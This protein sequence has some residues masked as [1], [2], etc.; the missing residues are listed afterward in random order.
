MANELERCE[1]MRITYQTIDVDQ[2][3]TEIQPLKHKQGPLLP[4]LHL[5]QEHYGYIPVSIQAVIQQELKL[6]N[7]FISG[8]VSFYELFH[9]IPTGIHHIGVCTGTSCHVQ[10]SHR[11]LDELETILG[12]KEGETTKDGQFTIIPVKCLGNCDTSPNISIDN[13]SYTAVDSNSLKQLL[14]Q[15]K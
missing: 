9:D 2:F 11:L 14:Q 5:A 1:S 8:V 6:S 4:I 15:F 13:Q 7:A 10:K 12:I 3:R